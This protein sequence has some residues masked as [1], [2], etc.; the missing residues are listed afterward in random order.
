MTQLLQAAR[1][2][3]AVAVER[4]GATKAYIRRR[5]KPGQRG[6]CN[7]DFDWLTYRKAN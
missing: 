3:V 2:G 1:P 5:E 6:R 7:V 4:C